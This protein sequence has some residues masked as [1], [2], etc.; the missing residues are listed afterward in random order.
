MDWKGSEM[1]Q[2]LYY[3]GTSRKCL[4]KTTKTLSH[5]AGV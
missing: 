1:K 5:L 3:L 2:S 4:R